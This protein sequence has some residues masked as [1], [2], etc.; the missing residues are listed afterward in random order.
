VSAFG[1]RPQLEN[2]YL[3]GAQKTLESENERTPFGVRLK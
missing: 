3:T 2:V 1:I